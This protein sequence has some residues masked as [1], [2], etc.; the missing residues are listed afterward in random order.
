M[1]DDNYFTYGYPDALVTASPE[2]LFATM[3][4][5]TVQKNADWLQATPRTIFDIAAHLFPWELDNQEDKTDFLALVATCMG[6]RLHHGF[7]GWGGV[8]W[9]WLEGKPA[10]TSILLMSE[11]KG[12]FAVQG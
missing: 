1:F 12:A 9:R 4:A 10:S 8:E 11:T 2:E 7:P 6:S 5:E 3:V